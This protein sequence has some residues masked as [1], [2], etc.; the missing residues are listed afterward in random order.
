MNVNSRTARSHVRF[1]SLA[2][3][4]T[5]KRHVRF[6]PDSDHESDFSQKPMSA[7]TP[8]AD[9]CSAVVHVSYGPE[10]DIKARRSTEG[11]TPSAACSFHRYVWRCSLT[12]R[13]MKVVAIEQAALIPAINLEA[14]VERGL[15]S[16]KT[17]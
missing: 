7:L 14:A 13:R 8:K 16:L 15:F 10:A 6:T 12:A 4:R 9:I 5:A 11:A 17:F 2:D 1:G 3:V